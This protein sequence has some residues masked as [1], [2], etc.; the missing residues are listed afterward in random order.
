ME[1]SKFERAAR[2]NG[3]FADKRDIAI[4]QKGRLFFLLVFLN[5]HAFRLRG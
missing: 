4:S 5:A 1:F 3:C 2:Q